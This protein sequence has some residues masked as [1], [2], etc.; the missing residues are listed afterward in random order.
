MSAL[1]VLVLFCATSMY[2]VGCEG[3]T[4]PLEA[5]A[6]TDGGSDAGMD[7]GTDAGTDCACADL[8]SAYTFS[9]SV[10]LGTDFLG[11]N[12]LVS[13]I[14]SPQRSITTPPGFGGHS[15]QLDG[16]GA[17][18]TAGG[19]TFDPTADHTVCWW[20][21]P[22]SLADNVNI[23]APYCTY[24]TWT[25]N[26][27]ATYR[28][29]INNCNGGVAAN[30][31]VPGVYAVGRWTQICQTYSRTSLQRVMVLNGQP[32]SRVFINDTAPIVAST[33]GWC[34]GAYSADGVT[35]GGFWN[36]LIYRPMWFDRVLSLTEIQQISANGC[37][38]P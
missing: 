10:V 36:G 9:D 23:F 20:A 28:W 27:G 38:L 34:I 30:F 22:A 33:A 17:I 8:I 12:N 1:R 7:A 26:G 19:F 29:R 24:D 2:R 16:G 14:G 37:C 31:D 4:G 3:C 15:L 18:C 21:Q 11:H 32:G 6:G 5:D 13:V 35:G 25:A